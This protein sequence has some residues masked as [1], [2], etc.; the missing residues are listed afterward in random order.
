[1]ATPTGPSRCAPR[2]NTL[3]RVRVRVRVRVRIRVRVRVRIRVRVR[4]GVR[5][6]LTLTRLCASDEYLVLRGRAA[7]HAEAH[8]VV[9]RERRHEDRA[10]LRVA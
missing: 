5:L 7:G 4:A 10:V 2:T 1:M 9:Q 8:D 6:T 3:A